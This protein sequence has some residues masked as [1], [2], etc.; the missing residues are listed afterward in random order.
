[1]GIKKSRG[2]TFSVVKSGFQISKDGIHRAGRYADPM[3]QG[4]EEEEQGQDPVQF[5]PKKLQ[6]KWMKL[7]EAKKQYYKEQALRAVRRKA[8]KKGV[9][10]SEEQPGVSGREAGQEAARLFVKEETY[11][12]HGWRRPKDKKVI[13][14]GGMPGQVAGKKAG[15]AAVA[16]KIRE[17]L[18][19]GESPGQEVA[20]PV[21]KYKKTGTVSVNPPGRSSMGN[22]VRQSTIAGKKAVTAASVPLQA[23]IAG[24]AAKKA[25]GMFA[26]RIRFQN[27]AVE[28]QRVRLQ[29]KIDHVKESHQQMETPAD[30]LAYTAAVTATGL[31]AVAVIAVQAFAA[32]LSVFLLIL[33]PLLLLAVL[34]TTVIALLTSIFSAVDTTYAYGTGESIV[35]V[36][37]GEIGYHE[38]AGNQTKYGEYTGTN[39]L[40]WCHAFVSW[41]AN[42][43]GFVDMG[44]FP[45]TASCET[46]RQWFI[47]HQEYQA[48]DGT[49]EPQPGD[50]IYFDYDHVGVSHHVGIVE[51]TENGVVHTIEGNKNDQVMRAHYDLNYAGIM[52]YGKPTYPDTGVNEYGTAS[53]FLAKCKDIADTIVNDG[54]WIY[55]NSGVKSSFSSARK[56]EVR[57]TNCA[58]YVSFVMQKFGTLKE[59]Q[60]FY[61][62]ISGKLTCS[63]TV[64]ERLEEYYDIYHVGDNFSEKDI[65]PGDICLWTGHTNVYAGKDGQG[66]KIWYDFGRDQTA[67]GQADSGPF[68]RGTRT[69]NIGWA[70]MT[71]VLRL[72]DQDSYGS[73][74]TITLPKG[75]G[76]VYSYMGWEMITYRGTRQYEL[77][78]QS[79]EPYD[80]NGFG[81]IN[82]RYVIACTSTFGEI[83]DEV[84]FVL[85]NGKVIHAIIGE[86]KSFDDPDCNTWG[87]E[88]GHCV[89]EFCVNKGLWYGSGKSITRYHPEWANTTVVKAVNLQKNFFDD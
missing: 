3:G 45:K 86:Y 21:G 69:G 29:S 17:T 1:M 44:I 54:N 58:L 46:G 38:G 4:K 9:A 30:A 34:V 56:A 57:K 5:L 88:Y 10:V 65:K 11:P 19:H 84:D 43:C 25:A 61:S 22:P 60:T 63:S 42:E 12:T 2:S 87:H 77:R 37:I 73:G 79:G 55:S 78:V 32:V 7:P 33:I 15:T 80:R 83:G 8:G 64:R 62:D 6:K 26:E 70:R 27:A 51:Y 67:D 31:L 47:S 39:G 75:L 76:D 18:Q 35:A 13:G 66:K 71:I 59:G 14:D 20:N 81:V 82:G 89:V 24:A 41:C 52:G 53:E 74:K 50:I 23:S 68:V 85:G 72:K 48:S 28:N 40:S 36:A 16:E 49:Y